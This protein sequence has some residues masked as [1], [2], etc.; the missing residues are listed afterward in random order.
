VEILG[1]TRRGLGFCGGV[2]GYGNCEREKK[3]ELMTAARHY[4]WNVKSPVGCECTCV[5]IWLG[6]LVAS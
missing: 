6:L 2:G 5:Q 1:V 4:I 3:E